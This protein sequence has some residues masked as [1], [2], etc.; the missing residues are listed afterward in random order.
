M[1]E[2]AD[3]GFEI[4]RILSRRI[5]PQMDVGFGMTPMQ[6]FEPRLQFAIAFARLGD[7]QRRCS[8]FFVLAEKAD[9]MPV[10]GGVDA[11]TE[12]TQRFGTGAFGL[13]AIGTGA[14]DVLALHTSVIGGLPDTQAPRMLL[15][16]SLTSRPDAAGEVPRRVIAL[17]PFGAELVTR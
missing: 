11:D 10:A 7:R 8:Q 16:V 17:D 6:L 2:C 12:M 14:S 5:D 4:R 13:S 9:M 3:E 1:I 15:H